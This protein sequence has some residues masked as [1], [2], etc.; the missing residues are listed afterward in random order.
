MNL[1]T[2]DRAEETK[3]AAQ[4]DVSK[5][6]IRFASSCV[7]FQRPGSSLLIEIS[8]K[9]LLE[10]GSWWTIGIEVLVASMSIHDRSQNSPEIGSQPDHMERIRIVL[11]SNSIQ[12]NSEQSFAVVV[13]L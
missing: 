7:V 12:R 8:W 4:N 5:R 9:K 2:S 11:L 10:S 13:I 6:S 1:G 3:F